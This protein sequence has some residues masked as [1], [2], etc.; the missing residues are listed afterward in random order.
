MES[1]QLRICL[2]FPDA[3]KIAASFVF[4]DRYKMNESEMKNF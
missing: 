4:H 3:N 1:K 2:Q